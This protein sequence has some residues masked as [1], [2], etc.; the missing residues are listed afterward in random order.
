MSEIIIP[1]GARTIDMVDVNNSPVTSSYG[2][3]SMGGLLS[4]G[5][6][7]DLT[8]LGGASDK[9]EGMYFV[10]TVMETRDPLQTIYVESWAAAK[11]VDMPIDDMFIKGRE[12]E[13]DD[14]VAAK[15]LD[16]AMDRYR[17]DE[18]ISM[19]MKAARLYG[20]AFAV[21]MTH[22]SPETPLDI[23]RIGEGDLKSIL[24]FDRYDCEPLEWY[25]NPNHPQFNTPSLYQFQPHVAVGGS[26]EIVAH[27]SRC[28]R[29]DGKRPLTTNSWDGV[30]NADWGISE[31][32]SA[33]VDIS[34]DSGFVQAIA[35]LAAEA[36]IPVVKVNSLKEAMTG[37][38]NPDEMTVQELGEAMNLFRS[39]FRTLFIDKNDEFT[40]ESVNFTNMA[41]IIDRFATRLAAIAGIPVTRFL[42]RS[43]A[44]LNATGESDMTNYAIHVAAM[45]E[46]NLRRPLTT[47]DHI[48]AR[49]IGLREPPEC[50]FR[51]L[52]DLSDKDRAEIDK[53]N[54]DSIVTVFTAGGLDEN[55]MRERL[56]SMELFGDLPQWSEEQLAEM[57]GPDPMEM[58]ERQ[59][60]LDR[61]NQNNQNQGGNDG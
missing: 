23:D 24:V 14:T 54:T 9:S 40:R 16:D 12:F 31:L 13:I 4:G 53:L 29:F 51:P 19:A 3:S 17:A 44:G 59:A 18:R 6:R 26:L 58:M 11:F 1:A 42:G 25:I 7:N 57:R 34:H 2:S 20:T 47:V 27:E 8:G 45:Q 43:P 36:S 50:N 35:H 15:E 41:D 39:I 21:I 37:K 22:N 32:I 60:E 38:P 10:P 46:R 49:N 28:L 56:S 33:L 61:E 5:I 30:Y 48:M 55:E 52:T